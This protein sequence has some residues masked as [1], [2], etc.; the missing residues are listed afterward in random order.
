M[1]EQGSGAAAI[2]GLAVRRALV[3][4]H[5]VD[6]DR[7]R[8]DVPRVHRW[9]STDA[10]WAMGR[11]LELMERAIA[12]SLSFGAYGPDGAQSAYARVITDGATFAWLCDV[13]VDRGAR[14][15]GLGSALVGAILAALEPYG[16]K[17]TMLVTAD[18]HE[19]YA[20]HGFEVAAHPEQ[21]MAR[22]RDETPPPA[23]HHD[24]SRPGA[25]A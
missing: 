1:H 6:T 21:L 12:G 19:V 11:P 3:A 18:A 16:L 5:E 4:G 9:L 25:D 17:R 10:Y 20:R 15:I 8:L 2:T 23:P 22:M 14:G 13:Y 7:A 24:A